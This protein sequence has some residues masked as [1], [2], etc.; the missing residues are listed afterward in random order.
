MNSVPNIYTPSQLQRIDVRAGLPDGTSVLARPMP[1]PG[2]ML[3][4]RLKRAWL[5]F[6]GRC[7]V[8]RWD[9]GQ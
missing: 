7:D 8:L 4:T 5:V 1:Y 2:W 3:L 9:G 6:T